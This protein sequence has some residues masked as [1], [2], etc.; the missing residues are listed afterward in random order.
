MVCRV[1]YPTLSIQCIVIAVCKGEIGDEV[2]RYGFPDARGYLVRL[3][4]NTHSRMY[5]GGLAGGAPIDV[6]MNELG[7]SGPPEFSRDNFIGL[8]SSWM[9][10][11]DVIVVLFDN[12]SSEVIVLWDVDMSA[13]KDKSIFEVPVF[14]A[15]DNQSWAILEY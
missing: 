9:S 14:Q 8:P 1:G 13:V 10:C 12:I 15:F 5:F 6:V 2:H 11:G 3:Q 7:H 4:W